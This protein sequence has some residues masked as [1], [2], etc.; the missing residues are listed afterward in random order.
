[1]I[2]STSSFS[3]FNFK[4]NVS[5]IVEERER[6]LSKFSIRYR[7]LSIGLSLLPLIPGQKSWNISWRRLCVWPVVR[8][9][10]KSPEKS[11]ALKSAATAPGRPINGKLGHWVNDR[12][13]WCTRTETHPQPLLPFRLFFLCFPCFFPFSLPLLPLSLFLHRFFFLFFFFFFTVFC[14]PLHYSV[15]TGSCSM[16]PCRVNENHSRFFFFA[17]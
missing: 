12:C 10:L 8:A 14:L 17:R 5:S 15:P 13:S 7:S 11:T 3:S 4:R 1:M 6:E 16:N 2:N 9:E